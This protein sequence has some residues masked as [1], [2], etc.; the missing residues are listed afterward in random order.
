MSILKY[1]LKKPRGEIVKDIFAWLLV[2][3][4]VVLAASSPYFLPNLMK[5]LR[6]R[7]QYKKRSVSNAFYRLKKE[8]YIDIQKRNHQ[9]FISLT[10]EG[11]QKAG[12]LQ[13]N[14]LHIAKPKKWDG[15]WRAVIF[16]IAELTRIKRDGFRGFLKT[17]GFYPLQQSVWVQPY[18][19]KDEIDLLRDFF[20]LSKKE[21]NLLVVETIEDSAFLRQRFGV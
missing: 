13:I 5:A 1:Y 18:N 11:K 7:G 8:G 3:G 14:D 20:G 19:C 17:L 15:K 12:A 21:V 9:I 10:P 2:G 4:A 6:K 16:D